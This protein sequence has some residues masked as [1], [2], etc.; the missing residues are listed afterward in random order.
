VN[1]RASPYDKARWRLALAHCCDWRA[2]AIYLG[3]RAPA[4]IAGLTKVDWKPH[5][6]STGIKKPQNNS[7]CAFI[8]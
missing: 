2:E 7:V 1:G 5:K 8:L 6:K 4:P 3:L